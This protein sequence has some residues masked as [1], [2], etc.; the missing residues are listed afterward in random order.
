MDGR[1]YLLFL[2]PEHGAWLRDLAAQTGAEL[3]WA[4]TWEDHAN[5]FVGPVIGLP[6]LPFAPAPVHD[7]AASVVPWTGGRPFAWLDD[8]PHE[9]AKAEL[10]AIGQPHLCVRVDE[11]TGLTR[12]HLFQ[13]RAWLQD[14]E[15]Q[16]RPLAVE[17]MITCNVM[18]PAPD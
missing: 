10:L 18:P 12:E 11:R 6:R 9:L 13:V 7:K 5:Q 3:A 8:S 14:R 17:H 1:R 2:N 15:N 4:S 16:P